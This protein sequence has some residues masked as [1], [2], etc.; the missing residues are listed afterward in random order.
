MSTPPNP[1]DYED[2]VVT[3][4]IAAIIVCGTILL[5]VLLPAL[6]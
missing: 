3:I 5:F 6:P 4:G 2:P 1:H